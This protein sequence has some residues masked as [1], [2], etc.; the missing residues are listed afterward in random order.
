MPPLT[1]ALSHKGRGGRAL[2]NG[3]ACR[4]LRAPRDPTAGDLG[5][6][7]RRPHPAPRRPSRGGRA[8][9]VRAVDRPAGG[10]PRGAAAGRRGP[11]GLAP[12]LA[13]GLGLA[14]AARGLLG[15]GARVEGGRVAAYRILSPSAWNLAPGGLLDRAFAALAPGPDARRLAP[16]L[17]SALNPC[18]P[19]SLAFAE[20]FAHA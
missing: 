9:P 12:S 15:H 20:D 7:P 17:I 1:P 8:E 16:L 4:R 18:V 13:S 10:L 14:P 3:K 2:G 11:A 19:V 5:A 6:R